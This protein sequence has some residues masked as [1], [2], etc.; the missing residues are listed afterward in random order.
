MLSYLALG[1]SYTIGEQVILA[2]AF[3]AQT[4]HILQ[5]QYHISFQQPQV[6]ATTG[7]TTDEL[8]AA[9]H[10]AKPPHHFDMVTLLIGVNNQYRG[11]SVEN[12]AVEYEKLLDQAIAF[13]Q[14][15]ADHVFVLSI[16]DWGVTPFAEGKD[17]GAIANEIDNY[18]QVKAQITEVKGCHFIDI[19]PDS[20]IKG[21]Q[22]KYLT[23][24]K[25]HYSAATYTTWAQ[26]LA[27][28]ARKVY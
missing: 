15:N 13:A 16:P 28:A 3:P 1:D 10:Q 22:E 18:N 14:G 4:V 17:R 9:I 19:T 24:D 7:W 5:T 6:I 2:E 25:L 26:A 11:K 27:V 20:R 21:L 8:Q 12:F 23:P